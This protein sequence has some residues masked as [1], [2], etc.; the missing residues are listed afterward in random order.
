MDPWKDRSVFLCSIRVSFFFWFV[1]LPKA[2]DTTTTRNDNI[3]SVRIKCPS[4]CGDGQKF[5]HGFNRGHGF[6]FF[7][8]FFSW[9][10]VIGL[11]SG[12][13][14]IREC[15]WHSLFP[16]KWLIRF[17]RVRHSIIR[18]ER[19]CPSTCKSCRILIK[20]QESLAQYYQKKWIREKTDPCSSVQ[21]VFHFFLICVPAEGW[22]HN[23]DTEK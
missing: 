15:L 22:G 14:G 18:Q 5:K 6:G 11:L 19:K 8:D 3:I 10:M 2:R 20:I 17:Y 13:P 9:Q 16:E 21:S 4:A 7:T 12:F 23:D 1:S